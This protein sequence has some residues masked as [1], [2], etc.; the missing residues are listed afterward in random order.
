MTTY[1]RVK[2]LDSVVRSMSD[3]YAGGKTGTDERGLQ[4]AKGYEL[5]ALSLIKGLDHENMSSETKA[6]YDQSLDH[7]KYFRQLKY[8]AYVAANKETQSFDC[9][10]SQ[11]KDSAERELRSRIGKDAKDL[12]FWTVYVHENG[13]EEKL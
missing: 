4:I 13:D 9:V 12:F 2:R 1:E 7:F 3:M 11:S 10:F 5:Q 6:L 8:R